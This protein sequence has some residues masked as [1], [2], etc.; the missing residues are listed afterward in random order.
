MKFG[1]KQSSFNKK[2]DS[3]NKQERKEGRRIHW[4]ETATTGTDKQGGSQL[5]AL[6]APFNFELIVFGFFLD[7]LFL[8]FF[9]LNVLRNTFVNLV[10]NL[11]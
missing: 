2:G 9:M 7:N 11:L 6:L 8:L 3:D 5:G 4:Q 1:G 10:T